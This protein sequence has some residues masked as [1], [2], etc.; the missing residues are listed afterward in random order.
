[1]TEGIVYIF[2]N[3]VGA[4]AQM[5]V[6]SLGSKCIEYASQ[7]KIPPWSDIQEQENQINLDGC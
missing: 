5:M 3:L 2:A 7:R 6:W 1:M 4:Q